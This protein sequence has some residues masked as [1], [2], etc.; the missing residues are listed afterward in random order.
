MYPVGWGIGGGWVV[1]FFLSAASLTLLGFMQNLVQHPSINI[2]I[3][4]TDSILKY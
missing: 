3:K 2:S 1:S 4:P